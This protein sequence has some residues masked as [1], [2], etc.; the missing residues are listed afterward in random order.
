MK[1]ELQVRS[2][3]YMMLTASPAL[4]ADPSSRLSLIPRGFE[5]EFRL[6]Y[7]DAL[8]RVFHGVRN[9]IAFRPSRFDLMRVEFDSA[10]SSLTIRADKTG[11]TVLHLTDD[12]NPNLSSYLRFDVADVIRPAHVLNLDKHWFCF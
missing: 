4:S 2:V 1:P 7:H 6:T 8:G 11:Q 3:S 12:L 10:N 9:Q 5:M